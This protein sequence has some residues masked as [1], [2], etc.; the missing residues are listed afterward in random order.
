MA[1]WTCTIGGQRHSF[2]DL[3]ELMAKATP[4]R[5]GDELAGVAR[6]IGCDDVRV[7]AD[8]PRACD[9]ALAG[10]GHDDAVL[11]AGSLYV[12]GAARTYL[13]RIL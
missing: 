1:P 13:R 3:R 12:A 11:V 8:V 9:A 10:A 5:S 2:A 7:Q 4:R 6:S